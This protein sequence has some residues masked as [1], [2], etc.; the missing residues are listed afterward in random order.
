MTGTLKKFREAGNVNKVVRL[1]TFWKLYYR[2]LI[3]P[4]F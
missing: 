4:N 3:V 1:K 2:P